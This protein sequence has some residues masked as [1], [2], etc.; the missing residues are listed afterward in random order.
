M[1]RGSRASRKRILAQPMYPSSAVKEREGL[2]R[3]GAE[4][5]IEHGTTKRRTGVVHQARRT[6]RVTSA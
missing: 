1:L 5:V 2:P 4:I 3:D 6:C